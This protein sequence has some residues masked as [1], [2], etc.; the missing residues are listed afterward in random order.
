MN[1]IR[2]RRE[3]GATC[4]RCRSPD[5]TMTPPVEGECDRPVFKCT[6]CGNHWMYG[7]TGGVYKD[8]A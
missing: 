6:T 3:A 2:K 8:N 5:Y 1:I 4:P 7:K